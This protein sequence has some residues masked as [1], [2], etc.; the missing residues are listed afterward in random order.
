MKDIMTEETEIEIVEAES[1][2]GDAGPTTIL[3]YGPILDEQVA[4]A[5][6]VIISE[7]YRPNSHGKIRLFINSE[8]G[9]LHSAFAL[10]EVMMASR[11]PIETVAIGQCASAGLIIFMSGTKGMRTITPTCTTLTHNFSTGIDGNFANLM[12]TYEELKAT[13]NRIISHYQE[14]TGMTQKI[15]KSK[16]VGASDI[17]LSPADCVKYGIAD[18]IGRVT[19]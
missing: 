5:Q 19:F 6:N 11:V 18:Q 1:D 3:L 9:E 7:Q 4:E 8:G 13:N 10:I 15:I 14:C 17:W 12:S 2:E 16:L